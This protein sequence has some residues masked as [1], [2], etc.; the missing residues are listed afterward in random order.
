MTQEAQPAG[1]MIGEILL[2][3]ADFSP[4]IIFGA[5]P[6]EPEKL[7]ILFRNDKGEVIKWS[8]IPLD[9]ALFH[10]VNLI[11]NLDQLIFEYKNSMVH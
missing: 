7:L 3:E 1:I 5:N 11:Q 10:V 2:K 8:T 4:N 6:E 9:H